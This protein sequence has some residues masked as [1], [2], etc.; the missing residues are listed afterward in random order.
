MEIWTFYEAASPAL[1]SSPSFTPEKQSDKQV[2]SNNYFQLT[3]NIMLCAIPCNCDSWLKECWGLLFKFHLQLEMKYSIITPHLH[4]DT[5][6]K[7]NW[8][9][10]KFLGLPAYSSALRD[11]R[12][13][14][15]RAATISSFLVR[16]FCYFAA[17]ER[18]Y[19]EKWGPGTRFPTTQKLHIWGQ[20][21]TFQLL[22]L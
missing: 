3:Y 21:V 11:L 17:S 8:M 7:F 22:W 18:V 9:E 20:W 14:T 15:S 12:T 19:Y 5:V 4:P 6:N 1:L 13:Q 10:S 16:V 2:D